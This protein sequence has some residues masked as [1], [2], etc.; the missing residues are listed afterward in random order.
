VTDETNLEGNYSFTLEI[1][2][3]DRWPG[4]APDWAGKQKGEPAA[5]LFTAIQ[6]QLGLKL[7]STEGP[8]R[9]W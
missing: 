8:S 3:D 9:F 1:T 4:Y 2:P 6:D 5:D 7:E